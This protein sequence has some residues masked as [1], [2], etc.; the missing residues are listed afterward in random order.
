M[1]KKRP[2]GI[3]E[4]TLI[5]EK[6]FNLGNSSLYGILGL[7]D[8]ADIHEVKRAYRELAK[9]YHPDRNPGNRIVEEKFKTITNAYNVLGDESQKQAYDLRLRGMFTFQPIETEEDKLEK[10]RKKREEALRRKK[11]YE[12]RRIIQAWRELE[13]G[14]PKNIRDLFNGALIATGVLLIFQFWFYNLMETYS[15]W[16]ILSAI[17]FIIWGNI[18]IQ[19]YN[20]IK[21]LYL[22]IQNGLGF[23]PANRVLRNFLL[24]ISFSFLF[25]VMGANL[26]KVFYLKYYSAITTGQVEYS[27]EKYN[28]YNMVYWVDNQR[29]VKI[30]DAK[31]S[32]SLRVKDKISVRYAILNPYVAE[33]IL[34]NSH[35][36]DN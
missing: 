11:E 21:Y 26:L 6:Y 16:Y 30:L 1:K 13:Y 23:V 10:R 19:N 25:G 32:R 36:S 15:A 14:T 20:Y 17:G 4:K 27:G 24:G 2:H 22:Q 8:F 31:D 5:C 9:R 34:P 29:Y 18:R 7:A 35:T 28:K 12:E 33:I 3:V